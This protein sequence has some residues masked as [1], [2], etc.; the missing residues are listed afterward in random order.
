MKA[1]TRILLLFFGLILPYIV[2]ALYFALR[3][4]PHPLPKWFPYVAVVISSAAF[5]C[6]RF[7][8]KES[9]LVRQPRAH[10]NKSPR[11]FPQPAHCED[12]DTFGSSVPS[13]T[14]SLGDRLKNL[15]GLQSLAFAGLDS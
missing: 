10:R 8:E 6:F 11:M 7:C 13:F 4:P 14:L 15:G 5:S 9:W 1:K 12:L 2:F 3:L